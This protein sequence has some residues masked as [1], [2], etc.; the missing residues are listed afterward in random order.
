[1]ADEAE[2]SLTRLLADV[3]A[4]DESA[5]T[6]LWAEV[7]DEL[8]R[9]AHRQ[10]GGERAGGTLQTTILVHEAYLRLTGD[11]DVAWNHSGHFFAAAAEA[12]RRI[13]V[14]YARK[15]GSAKRGGQR[16]R[17][18]LEEEGP[19]VLDQDADE[20]LAVDEALGRLE[21]AAPRQ[22]QVVKL[23]Y[24]AGLTGE[25]IAAVVGVSPRTVDSDWRFART[26]LFR[27]LGGDEGGGGK[28]E[29]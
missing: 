20:V 28:G 11:G 16:R 10:M 13:C 7:Y 2:R 9:M 23:R 5:R 21:Q 24:F 1:M 12:M 8:R 29:V 18:P 19:A 6:R 17:V 25:Q 3:G 14:D 26:W 15:R 4:G 22:A 27:E